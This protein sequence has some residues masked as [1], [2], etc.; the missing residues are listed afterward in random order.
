MLN[1]V[2]DMRLILPLAAL[3]TLF[4]LTSGC[5][6]SETQD[7]QPDRTPPAGAAETSHEPAGSD[8]PEPTAAEAPTVTDAVPPEQQRPVIIDDKGNQ[9]PV[10]VGAA[11]NYV[12]D[13]ACRDCHADLFDSFQQVGMARSVSEPSAENMIEDYEN[14]YFY[15]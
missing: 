6:P 10:T 12:P 9:I 4:F 13:S 8:S 5:K 7:R 15:H 14:N 1:R 11:P 3:A 2:D